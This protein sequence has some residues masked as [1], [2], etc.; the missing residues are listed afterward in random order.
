MTETWLDT[1]DMKTLAAAALACLAL[2]LLLAGVAPLLRALR[3]GRSQET[4]ERALAARDPARTDAASGGDA[5][6]RGPL[7]SAL[8]AATALGA[9]WSAGQLGRTLLPPPDRQLVELAGYTEPARAAALFRFTR[10]V[11]GV[12]LPALS[13]ALLGWVR[14]A[15]SAALGAILLLFCGFAVGWML[16]KWV[17]DKR[18]KRRK[19]GAKEELPLLLDLLRLLQGVGLS[20]DQSL[21]VIVTEFTSV[22]PVLTAELRAAVD[23]YTRGRTRQQSLARL[24]TGFGNDDLA[25]L[26][27]LIAQVD[28]HGGAIQEPLR[29]FSERVREQRKLDLK[30]Q[31]GRLTVKMTGVMVL[32]LMPALLII[33]GGAGFLAIIR[34]LSRIG[35][36]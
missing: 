3:Q 21:H 30:E 35:G 14:V 25:A 13:L 24:S 32:T 6:T 31:I 36:S 11:L 26:C 8:A 34:G 4:V 5:P 17:V 10:L 23:Q 1:L 22:M 28:E 16:P 19:A 18:V 33:T 9:Q 15:G 29:H 20:V 7:W 12:G 2:A 27:R